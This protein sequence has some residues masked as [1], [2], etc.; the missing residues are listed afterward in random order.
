VAAGG[1]SRQSV[2]RLVPQ[3]G[4]DHSVKLGRSQ[5]GVQCGH[6]R[7][8]QRVVVRFQALVRH[9]F[10]PVH[11]PGTDLLATPRLGLEQGDPDVCQANREFLPLVLVLASAD[12]GSMTNP[13]LKK[14]WHIT[15]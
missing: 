9:I 2:P 15:D 6:G 5:G 14:S 3:F 8:L 12:P 7:P 4:A 10:L 1:S 13:E 11:Q